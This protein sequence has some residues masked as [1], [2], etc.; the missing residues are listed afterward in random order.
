MIERCVK[1]FSLLIWAIGCGLWAV[2]ISSPSRADTDVGNIAVIEADPTILQPGELFDLN[3][4]TLTFTPQAGGGYTVS[5]GALSFDMNLG[6]NLNLGDDASFSQALSFTFPYFGVNRSAVFINS[7]GYLTF[8]STSA[9]VHFNG[10][11]GGDVSTLGDASTVLV[12]MAEG[13]PR[14]AV[15]WQD[16][17]PSSGGGVFANSL[18]DRLTVT[19]QNVPLFGTGTT[20]NFQVVLFSSGVI[21]MN[22]QNVTTTPGGGYLVGVS[23]GASNEA[24]V[25]T[26]NFSQGSG[27]SIS[28]LPTL[29]PLAQVFGTTSSPLVHV[30][31]VARR[32]YQTH[33]DEFDQLVMIT[34]FSH[35]MGNAF[36][37]H[38]RVRQSVQGTGLGLSNFSSF[39][40]SSG[41]LQSFLNMNRLSLYPADPNSLVSGLGTNSTLDVMGQESGHMWLA[42]TEFDNGGVCSSLLLGRDLAHWS[43]FH[44][45][46][47]SDM[48]GNKW[49]DNGDG[50]FTTTE[51]TSRFSPLDQYIMGLRSSADVSTFFF[52]NS[53]FNTGGRTSASAPE[54]AVTVNGTRQNVALGQIQ[55]CEGARS[56]SSGFSGVNSTTTWKQAFVL[57][58]NGGTTAPSA[59]TTKLDTIRAAWEAYF[60][61]ATGGR[62]AVNTAL[63]QP[64]IS[65]TPSLQ[66]F[67]S[68]N[69]GS[70]ADKNFTV[71]NS[72]G[73]TLSGSA[74][75]SSPF[76]IVSGGSY[77][78]GAGASQ[79]VTARFSP[80]SAGTFM[81][82][83]T[84][85]G[86]GGATKTL[87]GTGVAT[88]TVT[89]AGSGDGTVTSN[90]AGISCG[91]D[92][93]EV[94]TATSVTLTASPAAGS[95]F[96]G[97]SGGG[98]S[99]TGTCTVTM[100]ANITVTAT[101]NPAFTLTV[102]KAG[103]GAGTITS[104][105]SGI[106]CGSSCSTTFDRNSSVTL[107]AGADS[108][109]TFSAW[110]GGGCGGTG[111]CTVTM[112]GNI[113]VKATLSKA[114]TD[115]P[116]S[117]QV[118][119]VK[120]A[121]I[122][123]LRQ[124]INTLRSN[125]SLSA[126]TFTDST[127]TAGATSVQTVHIMDLR[128]AL[129]G[130]YD[131]LSRARPTYTDSTLTGS[132]T[133][134]KKAHIQEI[135]S[136][137]RG[138]E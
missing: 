60:S 2:S 43:F 3:N 132:Q 123:E 58:I 97:W 87:T 92:C 82:N 41:R 47:A 133:V 126:I 20:A 76:S 7:N 16:W 54:I 51:A 75:T 102:T 100:T 89:K 6:A 88:L 66:D 136:A 40:G 80:T 4:Q 8:A 119:L 125:N 55:T 29:E 138:V 118:T 121:H 27:S 107:S 22:Y 86:G 37:F 59:D 115:D 9:F 135:R 117:A 50:T 120:A 26:V 113:T 30:T 14:I 23:P 35:A 45:T 78:L 24:L 13:L 18:S 99:G 28:T 93:T 25:T 101:F 38:L 109:S 128:S 57:L 62:G 108:G 17:D 137:V 83:V 114:F 67:G 42:F 69:I 129:N 1:R 111:T 32:F 52:I 68:V 116:L 73:G 31:A 48:E 130:V 91:A 65:V 10:Q 11:S 15:L 36:A 44:D 122:T 98:C 12:Q 112:N 106:T 33:G 74:S 19:W 95:R 70:T 72:G 85:T 56:P 134:I 34:N 81:G 46:D 103:S 5:V 90:P 39:G 131:A 96:V 71:Q 53:P 61:S 110:S 127:L 64:A 21:Q 84:F 77:S 105:P 94:Y 49:Q 63:P 104:G 79:T 124:A